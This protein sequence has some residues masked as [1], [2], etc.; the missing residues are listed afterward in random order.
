M[1]LHTERTCATSDN[2]SGNLGT[3]VVVPTWNIMARL[4]LNSD[5]VPCCGESGRDSLHTL[6]T[7]RT[8]WAPSGHFDD[9]GAQAP[10]VCWQ[11][12]P[13][14]LDYFGCHE[15]Y[16][17][18]N[19]LERRF[20]LP[21][22]RAI[23]LP[24][25]AEIGQFTDAQ[26]VDKDVGTCAH[27]IA[28][29]GLDTRH[30]QPTHKHPTFDIAMDDMSPVKVVDALED[31][32]GVHSDQRLIQRSEFSQEACNRSARHILQEYISGHTVA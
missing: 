5:P 30:T 17:S 32:T 15:R 23:Q 24:G 1:T 6:H 26:L 28:P 9:S 25:G 3:V 20:Q 10:N 16:R 27:E 11:A 8:R 2:F 13:R 4:V 29:H 12:V 7:P 21:R 19:C 31:L 18:A 14:L 22:L